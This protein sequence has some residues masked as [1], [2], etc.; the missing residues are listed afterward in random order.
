MPCLPVLSSVGELR[1]TTLDLTLFLGSLLWDR[2]F[3]AVGEGN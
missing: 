2:I 3:P 1:L